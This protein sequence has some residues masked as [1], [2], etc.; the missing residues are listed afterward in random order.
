M[1]FV[2]IERV[3]HG[4]MLAKSIYDY[5]TRTLLRE[6]KLLSDEIIVRIRERGYP[7]IYIEDELTKDVVIQDAITA[8]LRNHAVEALQELDLEEAVN[9]AESIVK[10]LMEAKTISLDMLDLRTF[11]DYTFR[12]SD[13]P[14]M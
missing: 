4:M 5:E 11:D 13:I 9:V 8:E 7:G 1:R 14:S 3:E 10:Q 12:H 2:P 6:G